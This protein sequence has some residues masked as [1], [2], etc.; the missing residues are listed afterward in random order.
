MRFLILSTILYFSV[1]LAHAESPAAEELD[2][3][4]IMHGERLFLETR[5]AQFFAAHHEDIN[6]PLKKGDP[7]LEKTAEYNGSYAGKSFN[8]RACH[9][10]DEHIEQTELG[11]RSYSD[12]EA[13]SPLPT[14][15]DGKFVTVRNSPALVDATLPRINFMLHFDGEFESLVALVRGT[16]TGRNMGWLPGEKQQAIQHI[17]KVVR[18]D[19]GASE[20]A[21]EFGGLSYQEVFSGIGKNGDSVASEYLLP[22]NLRIDSENIDCDQVFAATAD[23]IAIYID[24]LRFA[25][26]ES[27]ISPYDLFLKI[28]QL[29]SKVDEEQDHQSYSEDL[30]TRI[31]ELEKENK[32]KFVSKNPNTDD[33]TF[34][35]HK[36][37]AFEFGEKQLAGMRLFFAKGKKDKTHS[38]NCVACHPAPHF[39]D[40]DLHNTGITQ[41]EY[42]GIHGQGS[43]NKLEIPSVNKRD[44]QTE[45]YLPPTHNNPDRQGIYR[46]IPSKENSMATDLGAWNILFNSDFSI[47][48]Q[49]IYGALCLTNGLDICTSRDDILKRSIAAFKTPSLRNLG[50]SAPY[51]HNGSLKDLASTVSIYQV[52]SIQTREGMVRNPDPDIANI[53]IQAEDAEIITA[54]LQSLNE[55]YH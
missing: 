12:F 50:H 8:C 45:L 35:F 31:N 22:K 52:L 17:C 38:G 48:Q 28:N 10:V 7:A 3:A 13:R 54:F 55:D 43:F 46:S 14:R 29:P 11:M 53:N 32:L 16:L 44:K 19:N 5:F 30:I 51:M 6:T 39:T 47:A 26:D 1:S 9:L 40:F 21:E 18:E 34:Q 33:G 24:D 25:E 2:P 23:L 4:E 42:D 15:D 36:Q 20:L 37:Q 49:S 27:I 41:L